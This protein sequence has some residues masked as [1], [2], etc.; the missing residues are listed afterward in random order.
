MAGKHTG[1][2][3]ITCRDTTYL[4]SEG[5]DRSLSDDEIA[6]LQGHLETCAECKI[7][8]RQFSQIYRLIDRA[9]AR[10]IDAE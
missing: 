2:S 1:Y 4:V 6:Q 10:D 7:A 9:L 3:R 5:R 8:S